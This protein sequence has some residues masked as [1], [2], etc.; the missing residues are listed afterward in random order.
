[1]FFK[2]IGDLIG[3]RKT[4]LIVFSMNLFFFMLEAFSINWVMMAVCVFFV[5][6][7]LGG[8]KKKKKK[9]KSF[10]SFEIKFSIL[11]YSFRKERRQK[12]LQI[13]VLK[14][15]KMQTFF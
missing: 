3:R 6:I 4:L 5:G 8:K 10:K 11:N 12:R 2:F 1:M 9:K 13:F 7:S 15:F 14:S